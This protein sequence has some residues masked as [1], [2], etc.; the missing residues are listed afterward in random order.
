M[1]EVNSDV[2]A[3]LQRMEAFL[4]NPSGQTYEEAQAIYKDPSYGALVKALLRTNPVV[5]RFIHKHVDLQR[6]VAIK[7]L[8]DIIAQRQGSQE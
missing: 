2:Q 8:K 5:A 3:L 1:A 7:H 4:A 6:P